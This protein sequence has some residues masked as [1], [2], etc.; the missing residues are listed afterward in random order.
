MSVIISLT[1]IEKTMFKQVISRLNLIEGFEPIER[2]VIQSI[3]N[4]LKAQ[5][6]K[7][8]ARKDFVKDSREK[9]NERI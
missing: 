6:L 2:E 8:K 7:R 9:R 5:Q 3:L 1:N 4:K